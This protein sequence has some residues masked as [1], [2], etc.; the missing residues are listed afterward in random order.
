MGVE[1]VMSG[2]GRA[3][4]PPR[5]GVSLCSMMGTKFAAGTVLY[6][7]DLG[8]I[9]LGVDMRQ[10]APCRLGH[11]MQHAGPGRPV[12]RRRRGP[13]L[14]VAPTGKAESGLNMPIHKSIE[15]E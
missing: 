2:M 7:Y 14:S 3:G 11:W 10:N 4:F 9:R 5:G 15:R 12:Y 8:V 13:M 6:A 1:I